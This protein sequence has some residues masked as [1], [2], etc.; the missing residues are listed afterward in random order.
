LSHFQLFIDLITKHKEFD[1]IESNRNPC[2][3][4]NA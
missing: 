3:Q 1:H 4:S 2:T